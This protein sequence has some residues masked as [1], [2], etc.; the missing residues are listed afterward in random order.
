MKEIEC[1][2]CGKNETKMSMNR[3]QNRQDKN[4]KLLE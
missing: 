3:I 1:E 4:S 2:F